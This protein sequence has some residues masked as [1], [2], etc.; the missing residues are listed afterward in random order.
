MLWS[1]L[2]DF[3][4]YFRQKKVKLGPNYLISEILFYAELVSEFPRA[5][6]EWF[7]FPGTCEG[8]GAQTLKHTDINIENHIFK[9][10]QSMHNGT[11]EVK[12]WHLVCA[13]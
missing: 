7:A 3:K 8:V 5:D 4:K 10:M 1:E 12:E 9:R 11:R 6:I 13:D 2:F